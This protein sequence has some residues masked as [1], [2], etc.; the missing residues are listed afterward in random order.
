MGT[1]S[2][3]PEENR[4]VEAIS[5]PEEAPDVRPRITT[6]EDFTSEIPE[7]RE[8]K[9]ERQPEKM[10]E[11]YDISTPRSPGE[12]EV[13][14][15]EREEDKEVEKQAGLT[16]AESKTMETRN[17]GTPVF[18]G[19]KTQ[20]GCAE[21]EAESA[22]AQ[23]TGRSDSTEEQIRPRPPDVAVS[24]MADY[25]NALSASSDVTHLALSACDMTAVQY[26]ETI[27]PIFEKLGATL[28][29]MVVRDGKVTLSDARHHPIYV[30]L[31]LNPLACSATLGVILEK[32]QCVSCPIYVPPT[33]SSKTR[34]ILDKVDDALNP[35]T[36]IRSTWI[37][38]STTITDES[39]TRVTEHCCRNIGEVILCGNLAST[40]DSVTEG[41]IRGLF[42]R[43]NA[44]SS[45]EVVD[46]IREIESSDGFW[47]SASS[48]TVIRDNITYALRAAMR[49]DKT[50]MREIG[51]CSSLFITVG[52][53]RSAHLLNDSQCSDKSMTNV[54]GR[55][56][57][58]A[59]TL[60]RQSRAD[61][62][63]S[64]VEMWM[65]KRK[66]NGSQTSSGL[67]L[68][69]HTVPVYAGSTDYGV[70][71]SMSGEIL[72][73]D[74]SIME[75]VTVHL[76][77]GSENE[78]QDRKSS[79][80]LISPYEA[81]DLL[82]NPQSLCTVCGLPVERPF[83]AV[84]FVEVGHRRCLDASNLRR[85]MELISASIT[86][87]ADQLLI[88]TAL[89]LKEIASGRG[90]YLT[91]NTD[92]PPGSE[93][94]G[95]LCLTASVLEN[96]GS[97]SG[98]TMFLSL[99]HLRGTSC[100]NTADLLGTVKRLRIRS[101]GRAFG[102]IL[103][104]MRELVYLLVLGVRQPS[105]SSRGAVTAELLAQSEGYGLY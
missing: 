102:S 24:V 3:V 53:F 81:G 39:L 56:I 5:S 2:K 95:L 16:E 74:M 34:D 84:K 99:E 86:D 47:A 104:E 38:M 18:G 63:A 64:H 31:Q 94:A 82:L 42:S 51:G 65:T 77:S 13:G 46:A 69:V 40:R 100:F 15:P 10:P 37:Q 19:E 66:R 97:R 79:K 87:V 8:E 98:Q 35:A 7:E 76:A 21:V 68:K 43:P 52:D 45:D 78:D 48:L 92:M 23:E 60:W 44:P 33:R 26:S 67:H 90:T 29:S 70:F 58:G 4:E 96:S 75:R 93:E 54:I 83:S 59:G 41:L 71:I 36:V 105:K 103:F 85:G 61:K 73:M 6:L 101:D 17:Q 20:S 14:E 1:D 12:T 72:L 55:A 32:S 9:M 91:D 25:L 88:P 62:I 27:A 22:S 57:V 49:S 28:S 30:S 11:T 80:Q 50:L 89:E